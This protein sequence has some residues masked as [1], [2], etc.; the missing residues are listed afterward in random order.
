ML[1]TEETVLSCKGECFLNF[2]TLLPNE[3]YFENMYIYTLSFEA[4]KS[5]A[6]MQI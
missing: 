3:F 2:S 6:L 5:K 1:Y 4:V